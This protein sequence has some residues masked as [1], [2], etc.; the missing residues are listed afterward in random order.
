[1]FFILPIANKKTPEGFFLFFFIL[2]F[3]LHQYSQCS[4]R[5]QYSPFSTSPRYVRYLVLHQ[6]AGRLTSKSRIRGWECVDRF[7]YPL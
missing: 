6:R 7:Y 2:F 4:Q 1:M 3:T 5:Y